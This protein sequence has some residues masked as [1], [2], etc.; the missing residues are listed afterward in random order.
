MIV[1]NTVL[2]QTYSYWMLSA[3]RPVRS[4]VRPETIYHLFFEPDIFQ[5]SHN[6]SFYGKQPPDSGIIPFLKFYIFPENLCL[7]HYTIPIFCPD[8]YFF[9]VPSIL[10]DNLHSL[11]ENV[12]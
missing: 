9:E 2:Q 4:T 7:M 8:H 1:R 5:S 10:N 11:W 3:P 6:L 12:A